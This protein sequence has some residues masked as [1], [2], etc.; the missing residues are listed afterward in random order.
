MG[1]HGKQSASL[2]VSKG[3]AQRKGRTESTYPPLRGSDHKAATNRLGAPTVPTRKRAGRRTM[4]S[5]N[6]RCRYRAARGIEAEG[7]AV[8]VEP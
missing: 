1:S 2:G 8:H 4:P 3:G 7:T 6:G 5:G